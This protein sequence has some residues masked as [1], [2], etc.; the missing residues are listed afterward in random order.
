MKKAAV[1]KKAK[2]YRNLSAEEKFKQ[3]F[4]NHL[5]TYLD[6]EDIEAYVLKLHL[7]HEDMRYFGANRKRVREIFD[8]LIKD[9]I[10]HANILKKIIRL[11]EKS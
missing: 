2:T 3:I 6:K 4:I 11:C 9:T 8:V 1:A 10:N 5:L 7:R